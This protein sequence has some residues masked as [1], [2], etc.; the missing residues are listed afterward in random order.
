M[1][2][3]FFTLTLMM[4]LSACGGGGGSSSAT[5]ATEPEPS[6]PEPTSTSLDIVDAIPSLSAVNVDP[7]LSDFHFAH[8]AQSDLDITLDSDCAGFSA[9]TLRHKLVDLA[10]PDFDELAVHALR[11]QQL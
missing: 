4:L 3:T 2:R 9:I 8:L 10:A 11:R 1:M 7:S 5:P 6:S